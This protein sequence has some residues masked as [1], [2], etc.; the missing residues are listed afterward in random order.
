LKS[1]YPKSKFIL[2]GDKND[3]KLDLLLDISPTFKQLV[4]NPTHGNK[5]LDICVTDIG[6]FYCTPITRPPIKPDNENN[7]VPSDHSIPYI[8]PISVNNNPSRQYN[9]RIVRP[10]S[11]SHLKQINEWIIKENWTSV[12]DAGSPTQMVDTFEKI[13]EQNLNRI[14]PAKI[15]KFSNFDQKWISDEAKQL[16][17]RKKREY[18][19]HGKS[20]KYKIIAK[21]F[22]K[23][24][25]KDGNK[26]IEKLVNLAKENG[27]NWYKNFLQ[28]GARPGEEDKKS[29]DL[30]K[31]LEDGLT[32][33][34]AANEISKYFSQISQEYPPIDVKNL[35]EEV[36]EKLAES[37]NEKILHEY[38]VYEKIK[39]QKK[40]QKYGSR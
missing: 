2:G 23:Q 26:F 17:R 33:L 27:S 24:V 34:Q 20:S 29:F 40:D 13:V 16:S 37:H 4:V 8:L 28:L 18:R 5:V 38:E 36:Q 35:S 19:K 12:F 14:C 25:K 39:R 11:D 6:H 31:H 1:I 21:N 32:P 9:T 22:K 3:L 30:P 15:I 10:I 7:G